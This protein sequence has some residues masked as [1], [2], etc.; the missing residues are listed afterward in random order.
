MFIA[1]VRR[2]NPHPRALA[3]GLA[4]VYADEPCSILLVAA[5]L[6]SAVSS[7]SDTNVRGPGFDTRSGPL[8]LFILPLI[9]E[10]QLSITG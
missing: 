4:T 2:D 3:N 8:L 7:A 5:G 1:A 6:H 9:H 10:G